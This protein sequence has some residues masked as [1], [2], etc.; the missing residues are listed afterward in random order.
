MILQ[1]KTGLLVPA[2]DASAL[3]KGL[4]LL[5]REEELCRRL[6]AAARQKAEAEFGIEE[7]MR[8]LLGIYEKVL[9]G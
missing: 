8:T 5:L 2:K 1:G 4:A 6:G 9:D 3:G 7:N